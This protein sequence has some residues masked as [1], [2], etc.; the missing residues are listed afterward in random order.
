MEYKI[1]KVNKISAVHKGLENLRNYIK[2]TDKHLLPSEDYLAK[3]L[4]IS[5]LTVREAVTVLEREGVV[6][7]IQGKGTI[8]NPFIK[9]L[10]NRID[11]G[12]NVEENLK[13]YGVD[14]EFEVKNLI[15]R[16]PSPDEAQKLSLKKSDLIVEIKK[17]LLGDRKAEAIYIDRIPEKYFKN[18]N[19]S[20][21][22]FKP[23]IFGVIENFCEC[24][25]TH[26]VVRI[27]ASNATSDIAKIFEI[28]ENAAIQCFDVLEYLSDGTPIMFNT[29]YYSSNT[30][31][32]T[33]C[34]NVA[35]K[36]WL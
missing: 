23:S 12:I 19:F 26:D 3:S 25:I 31:E 8:I 11:L 35:Y 5:R 4:G 24:N 32:F 21:N 18:K 13:N 17:V 33:L 2:K 7:K 36:P 28:P 15:L 22:D 20:A 29:E 27:Y 34:R 6:S 16:E 30:M 14:V 10:E 1:K 9:R